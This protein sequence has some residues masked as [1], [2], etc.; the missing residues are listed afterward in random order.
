NRLQREAIHSATLGLL[1]LRIMFGVG[2]AIQGRGNELLGLNILAIEVAEDGLRG[3]LADLIGV[4]NG[5]G[6]NFA[7]AN[8]L[9]AFLLTVEGDDFYLVGFAGPFKRRPSAESRGI[10]DRENA[11]KIR[12]S[13]KRILSRAVA[14]VFFS[15]AG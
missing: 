12:M 8:R 3:L 14:F 13:L 1:Q 9:F 7:V 6:V 2:F 11:G 15:F 5:V 4:L 10:V